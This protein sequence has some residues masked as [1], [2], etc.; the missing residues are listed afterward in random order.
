[1]DKNKQAIQYMK[2]QK[3]EK[4]A[5][6]FNELI[7]EN[8]KDPIG[9]INFGNLLLHMNDDERA[10]RFFK[11]ALELDENAAT[12]YYGLGNTYF[13]RSDYDQAKVHFQYAI[14][15]GLQEADVYY[16]LGYT[17]QKQEQD[18]LA[19]PFLLRATELDPD[20]VEFLFQY[21]LSLAQSELIDQAETIFQ[22]V[23]NQDEEHSDAYYNLGVISLF[24]EQA[25]TALEY[26]NKAVDIQPD[27]L[28]AQNGK[29]QVEIALN[30]S[31][32]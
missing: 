2:E 8:P 11:R 12:A 23:L 4:A 6:L 25:E 5:V 17:L 16:M 26:F 21:G 28:L 27:H 19:I 14:D 15:H 20:N 9:F 1:M 29:K 10:E 13:E 22:Q 31:N 30:G 18:R 24:K 3:Y 32:E 7:E